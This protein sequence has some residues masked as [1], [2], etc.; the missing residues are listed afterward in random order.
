MSGRHGDSTRSLKAVSP[1]AI[2]GQPVVPQ[3]VLAATYHL[4]VDE[5]EAPDSYGRGSNPTWDGP[6]ADG[7]ARISLGIEDTEDLV[8]DIEQALAAIRR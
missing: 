7:F 4:A 6:V 8:A 5:A 2:P 1:Q 3:A